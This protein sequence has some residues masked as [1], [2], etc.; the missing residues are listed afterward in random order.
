MTYGLTYEI[1]FQR[2]MSA[3][4]NDSRWTIPV[5]KDATGTQIYDYIQSQISLIADGVIVYRIVADGGVLAG[6]VAINTNT[7]STGP[8]AQQLRPAFLQF[9]DQI[10]QIISKFVSDNQFLQDVLY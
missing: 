8:V 6:F 2:V 4:I 7:G 3:V 1:D 5:L 9:S 10:S